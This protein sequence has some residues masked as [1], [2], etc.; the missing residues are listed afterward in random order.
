[1]DNEDQINFLNYLKALKRQ[2]K[3]EDIRIE[4]WRLAVLHSEDFCFAA[5]EGA[6]GVAKTNLVAV[7]MRLFPDPDKV[8]EAVVKALA[9][10]SVPICWSKPQEP[11]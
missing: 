9:V 3:H 7:T 6:Q 5:L 8:P 1:M 10:A 4:A 2:G 11:K